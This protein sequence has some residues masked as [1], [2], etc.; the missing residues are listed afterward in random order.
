MA[1]RE[2]NMTDTASLTPIELTEGQRQ[3]VVIVGGGIAGLYCARQLAARASGPIA[4]LELRSE[5]GGRIET[6][7]IRG[8]VGNSKV[9]RPT[10]KA[11]FGPMRFELPLQ[12]RFAELIQDLGITTGRFAPPTNPVSRVVYPLDPLECE[13]DGVTGLRPLELLKLGVFKMF[14]KTTETVAGKAGEGDKIVLT[15]DDENRGWLRRLHDDGTPGDESGFDRLREQSLSVLTRDPLCE[16]GFWDALDEVLTP[17]AVRKIKDEGTFYHLLAQNPSA[18]EWA[19]FWL[20]LFKLEDDWLSTIPAGVQTVTQRLQTQLESKFTNEVRL[21]PYQ[22]VTGVRVVPDD[23]ALIE[24]AV[25]DR[26]QAVPVNRRILA[27]HVILALPKAPLKKLSATF[28]ALVAADLDAVVG[29][30]LL[31]I[32]LAGRPPAWWPATD[33]PAPQTRA[34]SLATREVHYWRDKSG[35]NG[36]TMLYMDEPESRRWDHLVRAPVLHERAEYGGNEPLK[37]QLARA[38]IDDDR[39]RASALIPAPLEP[40]EALA[41]ATDPGTVRLLDIAERLEYAGGLPELQGSQLEAFL[42]LKPEVQLLLRVPGGQVVR[43]LDTVSDYAIR[44]WSK[45]PFGAGCHAWLPGARSWEIRPRL[46]AFGLADAN[47]GLKNA[48][49]CGE[50][51]SDYQGFIEGALRSAADAVAT[52]L[53]DVSPHSAP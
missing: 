28:P 37:L 33:A 49:I 18:V 30:N 46:R 13:R 40:R 53:G 11:E 15:D 29:F 14:G 47:A 5:F 41:D 52:I 16:T 31:K 19:I 50:A 17:L 27:E 38:L 48:H 20:R 4:V 24:I 35:V 22:E 9:T 32:F 44:D 25:V 8:F 45:P 21:H 10:F 42:R 2:V 23:P 7:E 51:Y 36:M 6:G 12:R 3:R 43:L 34:G 39:V 1:P 26:S